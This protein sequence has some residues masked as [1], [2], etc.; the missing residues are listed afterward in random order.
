MRF[1]TVGLTSILMLQHFTLHALLILF[2]SI[3]YNDT[4][5]AVEIGNLIHQQTQHQNTDKATSFCLFSTPHP[6]KRQL[7]T[8]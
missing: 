1:L 7:P 6:S 8:L 2:L 3:L 4:S 5:P